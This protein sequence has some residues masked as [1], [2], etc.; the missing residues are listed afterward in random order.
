MC[1]VWVVLVTAMQ[2]NDVNYVVVCYL[3]YN[4]LM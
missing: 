1:Q 3:S 4:P 2:T